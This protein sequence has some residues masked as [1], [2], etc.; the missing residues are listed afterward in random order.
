MLSDS[1]E[2]ETLGAQGQG[3]HKRT[4]DNDNDDST[5]LAPSTKKP[6]NLE[7]AEQANNEVPVLF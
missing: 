6:R 1:D 7:A 3:G 2:D 4:A 5:M